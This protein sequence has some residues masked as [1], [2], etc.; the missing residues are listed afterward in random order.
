[1]DTRL[2]GVFFSLLFSDRQRICPL[3]VTA[4]APPTKPFFARRRQVAKGECDVA[5]LFFGHR[6][7]MLYSPDPVHA[8]VEIARHSVAVDQKGFDVGRVTKESP[9]YT[10]SFVCAVCC[11]DHLPNWQKP[12]SF[13]AEDWCCVSDTYVRYYRITYGHISRRRRD[14]INCRSTCV[15]GIPVPTCTRVFSCCRPAKITPPTYHTS[16]KQTYRS[17]EVRVDSSASTSI[18]LQ[19]PECMKNDQVCCCCCTSSSSCSTD[20]ST[21]GNLTLH[22]IALCRNT[23]DNIDILHSS[24]S[25]SRIIDCCS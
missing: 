15:R 18:L 1:M 19:Q 5:P 22:S 14:A 2:C 4:D 11:G 24:S 12:P 9:K 23:T 17:Y 20:S 6:A 8:C 7:S 10:T 13:L 16:M 25:S 3:K 21:I